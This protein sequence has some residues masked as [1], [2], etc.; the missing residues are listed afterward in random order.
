MGAYV[1]WHRLLAQLTVKSIVK[2]LLFTVN[3]YRFGKGLREI[4]LPNAIFPLERES[5]RLSE[6]NHHYQSIILN[7]KAADSE[8][9]VLSLRLCG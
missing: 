7:R 4:L 1:Y 2:L 6:Y 9:N 8:R 3:A 5:L